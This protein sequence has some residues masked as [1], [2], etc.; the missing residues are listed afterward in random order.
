MRDDAWRCRADLITALPL[1]WIASR[2]GLH[3]PPPEVH[4]YLYDRYARLAEHHRRRG[5]R[6]RAA[7][8]REKAEAHFRRSGYKGPPFAAALA[9]PVPRPPILT[10]AVA[11]DRRRDPDDAA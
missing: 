11:T 5:H 7:R 4:F 3:E 9:M 2:G 10:R 6:W 8:L 1:V